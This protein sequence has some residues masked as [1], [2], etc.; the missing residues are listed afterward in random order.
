VHDWHAHEVLFVE[1]RKRMTHDLTRY[2]SQ[3]QE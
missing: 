3:E 1:G 2:C